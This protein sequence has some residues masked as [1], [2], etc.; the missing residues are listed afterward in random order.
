M[1]EKTCRICGQPVT[2]N[3]RTCPGECRRQW[4]N[5]YHREYQKEYRKEYYKRPEVK[6]KRREYYA[7][8]RKRPAPRAKMRDYQ[9]EYYRRPH[10]QEQ[11][12]KYRKAYWQQPGNKERH[13]E[14]VKAARIAR[15]IAEGKSVPKP[16]NDEAISLWLS[17]GFT[18]LTRTRSKKPIF[19]ENHER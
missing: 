15:L 14:Q 1:T 2:G 12:K 18:P 9:R 4:I 11:V 5:Q 7:K 3:R 6:A 10:V 19:K 13:W 17:D 16:L 8:Y